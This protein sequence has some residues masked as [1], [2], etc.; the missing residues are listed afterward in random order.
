MQ[1]I[2]LSTR[3]HLEPQSESSQPSSPTV[4]DSKSSCGFEH[5]CHILNGRVLLDVM[6]GGKDITAVGCHDCAQ[7][8]HRRKYLRPAAVRKQMLLVDSAPEHHSLSKCL[9][10]RFGFHVFCPGLDGVYSVH[11]CVDQIFDQREYRAARMQEN[12]DICL[13]MN[14]C[15]Y[16]LVIGRRRPARRPRPG[17]RPRTAG[18]GLADAAD[19]EQVGA[20]VVACGRPS[21]PASRR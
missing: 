21:P 4:P 12:S 19:L 2:L 9:L 1:S 8:F 13:L 5:A 17:T 14:K 20:G 11:A 3:D 18:A 10:Q 16:F 7:F 15:E 6:T